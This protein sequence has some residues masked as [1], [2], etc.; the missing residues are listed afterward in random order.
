[1]GFVFDYGGQIA[2]RISGKWKGPLALA[3]VARRPHRLQELLQR[4]VSKASKTTLETRPNPYDVYAQGMA[5]SIVGPTWF[6]C[7]VGKQYTAV[8]G[9]S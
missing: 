6:T 3:E 2:T 7:C 5:A 4:R 9:S 1:M 8:R